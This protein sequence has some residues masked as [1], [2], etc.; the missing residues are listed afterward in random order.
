MLLSCCATHPPVALVC[1]EV[2]W[3]GRERVYSLPG[4]VDKARGLSR[5]FQIL[6]TVF[7]QMATN[8]REEQE[9]KMK[10][11]TDKSNGL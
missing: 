5:G 3:F 6:C 1:G 8:Q 7:D 9:W 10:Q 4:K 11:A 2:V